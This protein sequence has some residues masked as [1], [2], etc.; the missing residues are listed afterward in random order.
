MAT[1]VLFGKLVGVA[2]LVDFGEKRCR[3]KTSVVRSE[4]SM[5][6]RK[7]SKKQNTTGIPP[8]AVA[9]DRTQQVPNNSHDATPTYYVDIKFKC[10][11]CKTVEIWTAKQ[12]KWYYEVAKGP[13]YAR[14]VRCRACRDQIK[15]AKDIQREQMRAAEQSQDDG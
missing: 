9:A 5:P 3:K 11:D 15:A 4:S 13:L 12:Q 10:C 8:G 14:A 1:L 6:R 2:M 7:Y